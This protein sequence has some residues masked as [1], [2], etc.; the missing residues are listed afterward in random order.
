MLGFS[1]KNDNFTPA[2]LAGITEW[3]S[4]NFSECTVIIAD[5]IHKYTLEID[6][7]PSKYALNQALRLGRA[8]IDDNAIIF[9]R[10][11]EQCKFNFVLCSELQK[12]DDYH[13]YY[14]SLVKLS[15]E[16]ESFRDSV[17]IF[18]N[19][20]VENRPQRKPELMDYH[21]QLSRDYFLE[22]AA[23]VAILVK[24]GISVSVY[25]G[26]LRVFND[27]CRGLFPDAPE[28]FKNM[29]SVGLHLTRR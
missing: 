17:D 3:I 18:A 29:I 19:M 5:S 10:H 12:D 14:N 22:E 1:L 15:E 28:E 16:N 21:K 8:A 27:L 7:V 13:F 25:P 20:F 23:C 6:G 9:N 4:T 11:Q 26:T 24:K 2:K